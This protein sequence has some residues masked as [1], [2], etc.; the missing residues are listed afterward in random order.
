MSLDSDDLLCHYAPHPLYQCGVQ[1]R[2]G[3]VPA[4]LGYGYFCGNVVS[5]DDACV[6][7]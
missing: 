6:S 7:S 1:A 4:K 3:V 2:Q 5:E